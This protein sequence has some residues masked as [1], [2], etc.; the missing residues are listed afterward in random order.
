MQ[1][2]AQPPTARALPA[3]NGRVTSS[4]SSRPGLGIALRILSGLLFAIMSL[5]VKL[6]SDA[7][8]L[9]QIVLF[10]SA[11]AIV[12]LIVF[13]IVR[14]EFPHGLAT[15]RPVG[16]IIR[17]VVGAT[18][19]FTSFAAIAR[20]PIADATLVGYTTPLITTLLGGVLLGEALTR[21]KISGLA[22][23][24]A[25]LLVLTLPQ[26][27]GT[28]VDATRL[29]GYGF[30]LLTSVFSAV[31]YIQVRRLGTTESPGTIAFYFA[32]VASVAALPMALSAWVTPTPYQFGVLVVAGLVGGLAHIAMTLAFRYAEVSLLAPFEYLALLWAVLIDLTVFGVPV[33]PTFVM[34]LPLLL[35]GAAV[36]SR[37][38]RLRGNGRG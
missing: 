20:L 17:S 23:G 14:N 36:S 29:A 28:G 30:G 10:R 32:L 5:C 19:M 12:P 31:A 6:V 2:A 27:F 16:H 34:A 7:I 9:G 1:R 37:R 3:R 11:F 13:L 33:G 8:P 21:P 18:G 25:G 4:G 35:A 24:V 22:L 26:M 15:K 38:G